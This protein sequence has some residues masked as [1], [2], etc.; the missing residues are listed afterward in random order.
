VLG[1]HSLRLDEVYATTR[2]EN[3]QHP[4]LVAAEPGRLASD[5]K[6]LEQ[7]VEAVRTF[8]GSRILWTAYT[9]DI[10]ARMPANTRLTMFTGKNALACGAKTKAG[11]GSFQ[12]QGMAPLLPDGSMP[13]EIAA[14]LGAIPNDPLW[15]RGFASVA[16]D[17]ALPMSGKKEL[18][19]VDFT[20]TCLR[21]AKSAAKSSK[22]GDGGKNGGKG[23]K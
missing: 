8:V 20:V 14:C 11:G 1:A 6:A 2:A 12:L 18:P 13:R 15:K 16:T 7:K 3:S 17:I 22:G 19:Q 10:A 21:K 5:K 4:C 9:R 23:A